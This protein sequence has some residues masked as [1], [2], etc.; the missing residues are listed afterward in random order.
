MLEQGSN[1][2]KYRAL[3]TLYRIM[4]TLFAMP[5]PMHR[6]RIRDLAAQTFP[7]ILSMW[8]YCHN[9]LVKL[10]CQGQSLLTDVIICSSGDCPDIPIEN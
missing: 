2:E 1:L 9:E 8:A 3:F 6:Q 4:K 10:Y 7:G 5:L